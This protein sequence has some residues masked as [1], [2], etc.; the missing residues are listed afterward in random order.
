M[1]FN[2]HTKDLLLFEK[3]KSFTYN[4]VN[5][6]KLILN[7][8]FPK[9][10]RLCKTDSLGLC[11]F[12]EKIICLKLRHRSHLKNGGVWSGRPICWREIK[13]TIIHEIGQLKFY[14]H[15]KDFK[16]FERYLLNKYN[17]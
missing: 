13:A 15:N 5:N 1:I 14:H 16:K 4:I 6:E 10:N 17:D 2:L 7:G 11:Y 9:P 3:A 8:F 12:D